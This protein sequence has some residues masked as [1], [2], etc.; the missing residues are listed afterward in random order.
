MNAQVRTL[1]ARFLRRLAS[2]G[3]KVAALAV[4]LGLAACPARAQAWSA[5]TSNALTLKGG[6][7]FTVN[8]TAVTAANYQALL[9]SGGNVVFGFSTK[10]VP[11]TVAFESSSNSFGYAP[12]ADAP[13]T[14]IKDIEL[15]GPDTP[16]A[17]A[18][19]TAP[20]FDYD[21]N[22][23]TPW[24]GNSGA[25]AG[26]SAAD[27]GDNTNL[28]GGSEYTGPTNPARG[29][30]V[31]GP[32]TTSNPASPVYLGLHIRTAN[33]NTSFAYIKSFDNPGTTAVT[34]EGPG[35]MLFAM[36]LLPLLGVLGM[37]SRKQRLA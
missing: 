9:R 8:G 12:G 14:A 21:G 32:A 18:D 4:V 17:L 25:N 26:Y 5:Y 1:G 28:F 2:P 22:P 16:S 30:F 34:P 11:I 7:V 35:V 37:G 23:K 6:Y 36:A 20:I 27:F 15:V 33:G 24:T 13:V 29:Q 19:A 3:G 31:F 10:A